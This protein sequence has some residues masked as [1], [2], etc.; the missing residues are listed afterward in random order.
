MYCQLIITVKLYFFRNVIQE[1][2]KY[3]NT[4]DIMIL[5]EE[6]DLYFNDRLGDTFRLVKHYFIGMIE[7]SEYDLYFNGRLGDTFRLVKY[8]FN[9]MIES[10]EYELYFNDR[11]GDTFR[12]VK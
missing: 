2:D 3:F 10:S 1:G 8:Y 5:G 7:S 9:G 12:L 4:G 6:F 11:L